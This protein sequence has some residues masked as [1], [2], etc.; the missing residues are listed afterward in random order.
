[1][2]LPAR[3]RDQ[4]SYALGASPIP[5]GRSGVSRSATTSE[6][7]PPAYP[8]AGRRRTRPGADWR[9]S[10]ETRWTRR[11]ERHFGGVPVIWAPYPGRGH[12]YR[13]EHRGADTVLAGVEGRPASF[14][15]TRGCSWMRGAGVCTGQRFAGAAAWGPGSG[16]AI[17]SC[18]DR[19]PPGPRLGHGVKRETAVGQCRSPF[20][21]LGSGEGLSCR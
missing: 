7:L 9:D 11:R 6:S 8:K 2:P 15:E 14:G 20:P 21:R 17:S 18:R 12:A 13:G 1:M 19:L 3:A 16:A 4:T 5:S 10:P